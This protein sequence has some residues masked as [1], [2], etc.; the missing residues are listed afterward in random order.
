MRA[1]LPALAVVTLSGGCALLGP[2]D[3]RPAAPVIES[4]IEAEGLEP[5]DAASFGIR[6]RW[7]PLGREHLVLWRSGREPVLLS[8]VPPC[9]DLQWAQAIR[10]SH[11]GSFTR[12]RSGVDSISPLR[13]LPTE[14]D[15]R[16]HSAKRV[17][18]WPASRCRIRAMHALSPDQLE[19]LRD[20]LS[21]PG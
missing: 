20:E 1:L 11:F 21:P 8:L 12:V 13:L 10:V 5:L 18:E 7:S 2:D 15:G 14:F 16:H 9:I 3:Y 19:A 4:F 6:P 17:G